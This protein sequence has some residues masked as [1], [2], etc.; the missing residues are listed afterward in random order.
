MNTLSHSK[1]LGRAI[2]QDRPVELGRSTQALLQNALAAGDS[3]E[4]RQWLAYLFQEPG[5]LSQSNPVFAWHLAKHV[6]DRR[7]EDFWKQLLDETLAPW[8]ATTAGHA[9]VGCA[10]VTARVAGHTTGRSARLE[11]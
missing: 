2:R 7:G 1:I 5:I 3:A 8:I 4:A 11:A 6:L 9:P 10:A